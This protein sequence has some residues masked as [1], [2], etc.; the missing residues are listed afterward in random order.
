MRYLP[1]KYVKEITCQVLPNQPPISRNYRLVGGMKRPLNKIAKHWIDDTTATNY[2]REAR[3]AAAE[4]AQFQA[5]GTSGKPLLFADWK[6]TLGHQPAFPEYMQPSQSTSTIPLP[7]N[8]DG[9]VF[10]EFPAESQRVEE[11]RDVWE[12]Y[13]A[14]AEALEQ[15][16]VGLE[17]AIK[18]TQNLRIGNLP[19]K[20]KSFQVKEEQLSDDV[21]EDDSDPD[22]RRARLAKK[23][24]LRPQRPEPR[25]RRRLTYL[26][27]SGP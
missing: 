16:D 23:R 12:E 4:Y 25:S 3:K 24:A 11:T 18:A 6:K 8:F 10:P 9:F 19:P 22:E 13:D 5:M 26:N 27:R 1:P 2:G 20:S 17:H 7:P 21:Y 14:D 15:E